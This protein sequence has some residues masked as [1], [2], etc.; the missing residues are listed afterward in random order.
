MARWAPSQSLRLIANQ[1]GKMVIGIVSEGSTDFIALKIY[2]LEW[3]GTNY[4]DINLEVRALQ[5]PIDATS[6][7]FG[8]GGWTRVRAWSEDNPPEDRADN[9]FQPLFEGEEPCNILIVQLDGDVVSDYIVE[10]RDIFL[11]RNP[12]AQSRGETVEKV[13]VRWLWG[14]DDE[15]ANDPNAEAHCL[16]AT[17]RALEAWFVAALDHSIKEP[18]E[19]DPE[20]EL[21]RIKPE[22]PTKLQRGRR[23][24]MKSNEDWRNLAEITKHEV[25]HIA[26]ACPNFG[27]LLQSIEEKIVS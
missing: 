6:G 19:L 10:F 25:V 26:C 4:G 23:R 24:L 21:I 11:P 22:L 2:L 7:E 12:D 13:L 14:S 3:A 5:P 16:V 1:I 18:E 27:K 17:V 20:C 9:L 15:R 8:D